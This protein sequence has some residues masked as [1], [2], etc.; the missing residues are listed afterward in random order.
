MTDSS[1][2]L[3]AY[4]PITDALILRFDVSDPLGAGRIES[5]ATASGCQN[6]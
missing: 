5:L 3:P 4:Y 1:M 6:A 2:R